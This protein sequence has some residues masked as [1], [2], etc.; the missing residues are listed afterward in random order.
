MMCQEVIELMQRYLDQDLEE[1]EYKQMLGHL[2][3]C[4]DCTELFRRLVALSQELEQLPKVKPAYSLVDAIM[5]KL[6]QLDQ[7]AA[8]EDVL[9]GDQMA[10]SLHTPLSRSQRAHAAADE[11]SDKRRRMRGLFSGRI[12]GGVVAA[13]LVLGF[14]I[15]D[16]QQQTLHNEAEQLLMPQP[17]Q[18]ERAAGGSE[19]SGQDM[20]GSSAA[21]S[22]DRTDT[23]QSGQGDGSGV[24]GGDGDAEQPNS[25]L[26]NFEPLYDNS[27]A[28]SQA[29]NTG[30]NA[31]GKTGN[32][33]ASPPQ[34][35]G[36]AHGK[37]SEPTANA[38]VHPPAANGQSN[39]SSAVQPEQPRAGQVQPAEPAQPEQPAGIFMVPDGGAPAQ[40][41]TAPPAEQQ[42][43]Q[44]RT[45]NEPVP[46]TTPEP[47]SPAAPRPDPMIVGAQGFARTTAAKAS[48]D[49]KYTASIT[50]EGTVTIAD[51]DGNTIFTSQNKAGAA[52]TIALK[53]W[54]GYEL[55]YEISGEAGTVAYVIDAE[56]QKERKK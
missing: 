55:T 51:K 13:G 42:P 47:D 38:P 2:Q 37:Q 15:V 25:G 35:G 49:G 24:N 40:T 6:Q 17:A 16:Q 56:A 26:E 11:L 14:F 52:E 8:V 19:R 44:E 30:S 53:A 46:E 50:G 7:G 27:R 4:P 1:I 28:Q 39:Q 9:A 23:E 22:A 3:N 21:N 31:D 29:D 5:P 43:G 41:P 36:T 34:S 18:P 54:D 10:A 45:Q 33:P 32:A 12:I 20:A 48:S